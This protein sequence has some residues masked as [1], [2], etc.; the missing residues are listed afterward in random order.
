MCIT[1]LPTSHTLPH[2]HKHTPTYNLSHFIVVNAIQR[3][4]NQTE[5]PS[6]HSF[7]S[8]RMTLVITHF[9]NPVYNSTRIISAIR[10]PTISTSHYITHESSH[11][12]AYQ[13]SNV[14]QGNSSGC[15]Y[16]NGK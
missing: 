9:P 12:H 6:L 5:Y 15:Q 7:H 14:F 16:K 10:T 8:N 4:K 13:T 3:V 11:T 1:H 2:A